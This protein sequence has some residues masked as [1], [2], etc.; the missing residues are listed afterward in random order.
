MP[1]NIWY[2]VPPGTEKPSVPYQANWFL[3]YEPVPSSLLA[4]NEDQ[5]MS[6]LD[7]GVKADT[8]RIQKAL[9]GDNAPSTVWDRRIPNRT[10]TTYTHP[11]PSDFPHSWSRRWDETVVHKPPLWQFW[12]DDT[13]S[14]THHSQ[15]YCCRGGENV[16]PAAKSNYPHYYD[17][18]SEDAAKL[19]RY[20]PDAIAQHNVTPKKRPT[21]QSCY[22]EC[23]STNNSC[24]A[25]YT[26]KDGRCTLYNV[27]GGAY[28]GPISN[29]QITY[30]DRELVSTFDAGKTDGKVF[31]MD[32]DRS[33]LNGFIRPLVDKDWTDVRDQW[34]DA[35]C[36]EAANHAGPKGKPLTAAEG[37]QFKNT[38]KLAIKQ[39][40]AEVIEKLNKG[41]KTLNKKWLGAAT[42]VSAAV[43]QLRAS[44]RPT[45]D[46][47]AYKL[48]D[49]NSK[50]TTVVP[51]WKDVV[52][53]YMT[54]DA[55]WKW[56]KD[57]GSPIED[58]TKLEKLG[59][60]TCGFQ[61]NDD[62]E[63]DYFDKTEIDENYTIQDQIK[64]AK[65]TLAPN[66]KC[67][68]TVRAKSC[69]AD[70]SAN[71]SAYSPH[72]SY[73][74]IC[75]RVYGIDEKQQ[76]SAA[77]NWIDKLFLDTK[78]FTEIDKLYTGLDGG[79]D[80]KNEFLDQ[81]KPVPAKDTSAKANAARSDRLNGAFACEQAIRDG[82]YHQNP[83]SD[84]FASTVRPYTL[85]L[86]GNEIIGNNQVGQWNS[87]SNSVHANP[88]PTKEVWA[89]QV[90]HTCALKIN[91]MIDEKGMNLSNEGVDVALAGCYRQLGVN[92]FKAIGKNLNWSLY[93]YYTKVDPEAGVELA[94]EMG[95]AAGF[96]AFPAFGMV[97][98]DDPFLVKVTAHVVQEAFGK[99]TAKAVAEAYEGEK[100]T[101]AV[102]VDD[103]AKMFAKDL[104]KS[105]IEAV[106]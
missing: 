91:R 32:W 63:Q 43:N 95:I 8:E 70:A 36:D 75:R 62:C 49:H 12:A 82:A 15:P 66:D 55:V 85:A 18:N 2:H 83:T 56:R 46:F 45:L 33:V 35:A 93:D 90:A 104:A 68:D 96:M 52:Q 34:I 102:D 47:A 27:P 67:M 40:S 97:V 41:D 89:Q 24:V 9:T 37:T 59:S 50:E 44:G 20:F 106:A 87:Y 58:D 51:E 98:E 65:Q 84:Q 22:D 100:I 86:Q 21:G 80:D 10:C 54:D 3:P 73:Q 57:D 105:A 53:V 16:F 77:S 48:A 92:Y 13:T 81:F 14:V 28:F 94:V 88:R 61:I 71:P 4:A 38:C 7:P 78:N 74:Q 5:R 25:G 99:E 6:Y 1:E 19:M 39:G 76:Y 31:I 29:S 69:E 72:M 101:S 26:Q 79:D 103:L 42:A 60:E 17:V 11:C 30:R 64:A 23:F